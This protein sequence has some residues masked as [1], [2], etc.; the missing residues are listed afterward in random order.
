MVKRI[1]IEE[2][3]KY[4]DFI[5]AHHSGHFMQSPEWAV[6]KKKQKS[7]AL[8]S[9]DEADN[10]RGTML[11][12]L[13]EVRR[14]KKKFLYSPR[15][16]VCSR[17]DTAALSELL[18]AAAE[19][20]KEIGAYKLTLDPDITEGDTVWL[21]CFKSHNS[22]IG[23]NAR[24]NAILQP[25]A[26]YRIDVA[27]SDDELMASYH[28]KARYSVRTSIKSG[29]ICRLG[30]RED[31]P[32][33]CAMLSET[34]KRDGFTARGEDYFYE[35]YDAL[36]PDAVKL[37]IV[38]YEGTPIAGSVLIK[39]ASKT[40][41]MYAGSNDEHKETLPNFLMQWEMMRWSRDNGCP[42]YD[43]RGIAGEGDKLKPIEGLVRFKKRFGGELCSFIGRI[44]II[45]N[46]AADF[47]VNSLKGAA[48]FVRRITGRK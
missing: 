28:S 48:A 34:A 21:D 7:F 35:M 46:S 39:Y 8:V 44:D 29:A 25:F 13:Q 20:A 37:F 22:R 32:C 18:D 10:P 23:D 36:G 38:E 47:Y 27:K 16:P 17:T 41:H 12:F 43:M 31:I 4:S 45:Y 2:L 3:K 15:G 14:T 26:V 40:W 42:S 30:S 6:F 1:T 19:L 24:D 9:I 33:F 11:L 5:S